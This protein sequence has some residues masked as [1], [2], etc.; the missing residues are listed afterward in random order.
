MERLLTAMAQDLDLSRKVSLSCYLMGPID[1][2]MSC[3][4]NFSLS[5]HLPLQGAL[6]IA[7]GR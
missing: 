2:V 4:H 6:F 1:A 7:K 5:A 3:F